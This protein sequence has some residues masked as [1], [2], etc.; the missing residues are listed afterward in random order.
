MTL[1]A[2]L[3]KRIKLSVRAPGYSAARY[4]KH[5]QQ[6]HKGGACLRPAQ[7]SCQAAPRTELGRTDG[8]S[9]TPG[10]MPVSVQLRFRQFTAI[11]CLSV[12]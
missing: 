6:K 10:S 4:V 8:P 12:E 5:N 9:T 7:R 2:R 1:K 11:V 3:T